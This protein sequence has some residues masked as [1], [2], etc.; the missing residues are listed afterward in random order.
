MTNKKKNKSK[1]NSTKFQFH[2][3]P[4]KTSCIDQIEPSK[5]VIDVNTSN[6]FNLFFLVL[7]SINE[8]IID[9]NTII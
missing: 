1:V 2:K 3:P 4:H 6:K 7:F 5:S 9:K 8:Y